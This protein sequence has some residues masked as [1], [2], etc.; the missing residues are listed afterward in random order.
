[1]IHNLDEGNKMSDLVFAFLNLFLNLLS[2]SSLR[3][4]VHYYKLWVEMKH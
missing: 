3:L 1:M 4:S 2:R